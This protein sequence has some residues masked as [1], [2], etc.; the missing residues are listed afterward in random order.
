MSFM[1]DSQINTC[2]EINKKD[3]ININHFFSMMVLSRL[4]S[5]LLF[6]PITGFGI[7]PS[8]RIIGEV[9]ASLII[10][11]ISTAIYKACQHRNLRFIGDSARAKIVSVILIIYFSLWFVLGGAIFSYFASTQL[12]E[13]DIS[14]SFFILTAVIAVYGSYIGAQSMGRCSLLLFGACSTGIVIMLI[15]SMGNFTQYNLTPALQSKAVS[16]LEYTAFSVV[17]STEILGGVFIV[18][19]TQRLKVSNMRFWYGISL[20]FSF[21]IPLFSA[22]LFGDLANS[23][24]FPSFKITSA[25]N[26]I[27]FSRLDAVFSFIWIAAFCVKLTL[28]FYSIKQCIKKLT[29]EKKALIPYI[30][31]ISSLVL[32]SLFFATRVT[33]VPDKIILLVLGMSFLISAAAILLP[34]RRKER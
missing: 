30:I 29:D 5:V 22:G 23:L 6:T 19:E 7:S 2:M 9:S 4:S 14:L 11:L 1:V 8:D 26:Y 10:A 34:I 3:K 33:I 25:G 21:V 15:L 32:L 18:G 24:P 27:L 12:L 31:L 17:S 16:I 20:L 13:G 28:I